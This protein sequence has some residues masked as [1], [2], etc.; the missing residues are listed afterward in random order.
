MAWRDKCCNP[1]NKQR[2]NSKKKS[3]RP[4]TKAMS[5]VDCKL[6][7]QI[8][9]RICNGCRVQLSGIREAQSLSESPTS[10]PSSPLSASFVEAERLESLQLV[11]EC[12]QGLG[13][14]PAT[15]RKTRSKKY[16][17]DKL[18]RVTEMMGN[19]MIREDK[20]SDDTTIK[21]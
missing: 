20:E 15:K 17:K 14:T 4:V 18:A 21:L 10:V 13:E 6:G 5:E 16:S 9:S 12:L 11:S 7:L 2:H 3:L 8:G 1:F 19:A